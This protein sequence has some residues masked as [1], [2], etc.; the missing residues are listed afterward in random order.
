VTYYIDIDGTLTHKQ[1]RY[2][3]RR[4]DGVWTEM[5]AKVKK[6]I[7]DGHEVV[8]WSGGTEYA[9]RAA[10]EM[11]VDGVVCLAKPDVLIDNQRRKWGNRLQNRMITPE[12]FLNE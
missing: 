7:A 9:K 10:R 8:L 6:L 11:G 2:W 12:A 1:R 5:V 3:W 4:T